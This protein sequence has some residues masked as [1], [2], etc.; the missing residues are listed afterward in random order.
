MSDENVAVVYRAERAFNEGDVEALV[1]LTHPDIEWETGL[2]GTPTY[3][4]H[5]GIRG[6]FS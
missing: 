3:R 4:G 6:M 2:I 1:S 5:D